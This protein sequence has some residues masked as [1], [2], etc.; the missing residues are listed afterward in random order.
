[1]IEF[2]KKEIVPGAYTGYI[3]CYNYANGHKEDAACCLQPQA[4][5]SLMLWFKNRSVAILK[6]IITRYVNQREKALVNSPFESTN[7]A[8]IHIIRTKVLTKKEFPNLCRAINAHSNSFYW[9]LPR[10]KPN[11]WNKQIPDMIIWANN[12]LA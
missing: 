4:V 3:K 10:I 2:I 6:S 1:M 5:D 8:A 9:I 7:K 11:V 12:Q